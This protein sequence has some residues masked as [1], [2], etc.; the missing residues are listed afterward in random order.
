LGATVTEL[1]DIEL[2][3]LHRE[4][5]SWAAEQAA[6]LQTYFREQGRNEIVEGAWPVVPDDLARAA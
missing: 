6:S 5:I 2:R 4:Q 1:R 3:V